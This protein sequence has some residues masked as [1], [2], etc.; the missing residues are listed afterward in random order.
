MEVE[1]DRLRPLDE[2]VDLSF[3]G[4][5]AIN[6]RLRKGKYR[7]LNSPEPKPVLD[8]NTRPQDSNRQ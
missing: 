5:L 1:R 2:V 4:T 3:I 7:H 6:Y 8:Q